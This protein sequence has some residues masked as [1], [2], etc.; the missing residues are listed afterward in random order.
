[1][2][3]DSSASDMDLVEL[4]KAAGVSPRTVRYYIHQ[5]LLPSPGTRGPNTRYDRA[6]VDRLQ[7]IKL[8]QKDKWPLLRIRDHMMELDD[9]GVRRE[10]GSP[11]E[12][13]LDEPTALGYV[14]EVLGASRSRLS[15]NVR[16]GPDVVVTRPPLPVAAAV[17][18][19]SRLEMRKST[20]ERVRIGQN[21]ELSIRTPLP[22]DQKKL[23]DRLIEA[24]RQIFAEEGK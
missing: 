1:M 14:R 19:E 15:R 11:P 7:L 20:W 5:G 23:V 3:N 22:P 2:V 9:D 21:V 4:A 13:P 18:L 12:L 10:L 16:A 17:P 6:L 24:A 8:L